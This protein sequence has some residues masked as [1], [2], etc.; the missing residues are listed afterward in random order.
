MNAEAGADVLRGVELPPGACE[1]R[2]AAALELDL[3]RHTRPCP[4]P[5]GSS[6]WSEDEAAALG[7]ASDGYLAALSG[8]SRSAVRSARRRRGIRSPDQR[9]PWTA[10]E[11][12]IVRAL[13]PAE[14]AAKTGQTPNAVYRRR[15]VLGLTGR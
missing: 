3:A 15:V 11:D 14:A 2:A 4:S 10:E 13:P 6:P 5:G 9:R 1:R 7:S 8:R 12:A